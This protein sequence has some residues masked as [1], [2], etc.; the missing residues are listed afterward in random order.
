[1][2]RSIVAHRGS[3]VEGE[4][5]N[6]IMER[7]CGDQLTCETATLNSTDGEPSEIRYGSKC[8]QNI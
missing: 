2:N 3:I 1:M 4:V 5:M 8:S 7:S 6:G